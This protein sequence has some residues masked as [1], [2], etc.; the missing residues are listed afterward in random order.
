MSARAR[1]RVTENLQAASRYASV[2]DVQDIS[3]A[4]QIDTKHLDEFRKLFR[5]T[6]VAVEQLKGEASAIRGD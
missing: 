6:Q 5:Q 4:L 1:A 3:A 2:V